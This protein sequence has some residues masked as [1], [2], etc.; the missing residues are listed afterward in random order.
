MSSQR[1]VVSAEPVR[2]AVGVFGGT[3]KDIPALDL[4]AA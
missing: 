4:G 3:L 2:A 1:S